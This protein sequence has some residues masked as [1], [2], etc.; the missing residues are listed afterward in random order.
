MGTLLNGNEFIRETGHRNTGQELCE[1]L[2]T[3]EKV[4]ELPRTGRGTRVFHT[5]CRR[6]VA[7]LTLLFGLSDCKFVKEEFLVVLSKQ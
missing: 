7:L 1:N 4:K 5:G 3:L 2:V 6:N